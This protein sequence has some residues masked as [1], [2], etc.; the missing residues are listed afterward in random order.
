MF[1]SAHPPGCK[2]GF[3]SQAFRVRRNCTKTSDFDHFIAPLKDAYASRGYDVNTLNAIVKSVNETERQTL[4]TT[5]DKNAQNKDN[6]VVCTLLYN[7]KDI[8]A[9]K[10]ITKYWH[11]LETSE[12]I[13]HLFQ[14]PPLF[15][16]YR[17][18][19]FKDILVHAGISYPHTPSTG[20]QSLAIFSDSCDRLNCKKM[21]SH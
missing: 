7:R 13:G 11:I 19:N 17:P 8:D 1:N 3:K 6:R 12:T 16:Y 10:I 15:G 2:K 20:E 21:Q 4:L 5:K 9:R 14:N 18:K